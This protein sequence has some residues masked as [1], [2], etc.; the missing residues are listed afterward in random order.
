MRERRRS[1]IQ[2]PTETCSCFSFSDRVKSVKNLLGVCISFICLYGAYIGQLYLQSSLNVDSGLGLISSS[3]VYG[4]QVVFLFFCPAINC[5]LGSKYSMILG[6]ILLVP[7][8]LANYYPKS[9]TLYPASMLAGPSIAL[10]FVNTQVHNSAIANRY[11]AALKETPENAIVLYAG[12]FAM[13][14]KL[15]QVFGSLISS[16]TLL[17]IDNNETMLSN[18]TC[19]NS[20]AASFSEQ[21]DL[22]YILVSVYLVVGVI[23]LIISITTID[24]LGTEANFLTASTIVKKYLLDST[25]K[26][27]KLL[28]HWKMILLFPML[29][30]NGISIGFAIGTFSKVCQLYMYTV[31][32][33]L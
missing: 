4:S 13:A 31:N 1:S 9:Y 3:L 24:H 33:I 14:V 2:Q 17:N 12:V 8:T 5:L 19:S 23:G 7:Y 21:D 16:V 18:E 29:I 26:I 28:I 11:A 20:V 25:F 6:Y 22:Y 32:I 27:L 10:L 30:V 15:G